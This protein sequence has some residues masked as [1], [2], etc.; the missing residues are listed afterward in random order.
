MRWGHRVSSL[1]ISMVLNHVSGSHNRS[2][3]VLSASLNKIFPSF[4]G[5]FYSLI[6]LNFYQ[7]LLLLL[8]LL[9]LF[10][11]LLFLLLSSS[12]FLSSLE[13][14]L[15]CSLLLK[16]INCHPSFFPSPFYLL[17]FSFIFFFLFSSFSPHFPPLR[18]FLHL[19]QHDL[20]KSV[21]HSVY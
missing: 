2:Y 3:N 6:F 12:S 21:E 11:L 13:S 8:L 16:L 1:I 19:F 10:M 14:C 7:L 18:P 17:V 15:Y 20:A 9:L 5:G 4:F